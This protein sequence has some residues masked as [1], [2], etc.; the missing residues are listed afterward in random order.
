MDVAALK[1][2]AN[3]RLVRGARPQALDRSSLNPQDRIDVQS[4]I[5]VVGKYGA[6]DKA[7]HIPDDSGKAA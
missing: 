5:W 1:H 4:F 3:V 2:T 7:G 6:D